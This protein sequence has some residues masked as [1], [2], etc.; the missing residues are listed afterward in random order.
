MGGLNR[1]VLKRFRTQL[2]MSKE[3]T[4]KWM[5][6]EKSGR[7]GASDIY[8][9]LVVKTMAMVEA[10]YGLASFQAQGFFNRSLN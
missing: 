8:T 10:L 4:E 9:D 2:W 6:E 5:T 1:Y 7:R 3:A